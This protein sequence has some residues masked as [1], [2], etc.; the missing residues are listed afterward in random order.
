M[1]DQ[2]HAAIRL[3]YDRFQY[4][5]FVRNIWIASSAALAGPAISEEAGGDAA[6]V[7][8]P[9]GDHGSPEGPSAVQEPREERLVGAKCG[10]G[11]GG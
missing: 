2:M 6:K 1:T 8:I 7:A 9:S 3:A 4:L 11:A 10:S 5:G